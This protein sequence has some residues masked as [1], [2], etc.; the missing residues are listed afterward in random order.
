MIL[1]STGLCAFSEARYGDA[2]EHLERAIATFS[3]A[4]LLDHASAVNLDLAAVALRRGDPGRALD[5]LA[6]AAEGGREFDRLRSASLQAQ[7]L[8]DLGRVSE[9]EEA[10]GLAAYLCSRVGSQSLKRRLDAVSGRI[11]HLRRR[12]AESIALFER[13][14][15]ESEGSRDTEGELSALHGLALVDAAQRRHRW[16]ELRRVSLFRGHTWY[17]ATASLGLSF[18]V[19]EEGALEEARELASRAVAEFDAVDSPRGRSRALLALGDCYAASGNEA[20][21]RF[22]WKAGC[23]ALDIDGPVD[24]AALDEFRVRLAASIPLSA[25]V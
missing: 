21:A 15:R 11:L 20:A 25:Q 2:Q 10:A 3:G 23:A 12:S 24:A 8:L 22:A 5:Q 4:A 6:G 14:L 13:L 1:H 9:A 19:A 7:A 17:S 16:R 18:V